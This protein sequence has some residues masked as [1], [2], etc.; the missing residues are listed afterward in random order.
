MSTAE[1]KAVIRR[2]LEECNKGKESA[3]AAMDELCAPD[4]VYHG[5]GVFPDM[6]LAAGKQMT[7][8][9]YTA[10]PDTHWAA[11]DLIAEGDKVVVRA[12]L[13][14]THRGEFMGIPPTGKAV[15]FTAIYVS[16]I[17]GGKY[18]EDSG[19]EDQLGLMQQL[20]AIPQMAQTGA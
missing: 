19:I 14:G 3:M 12:T 11:E 7:I 4:Y 16:R 8:A 5:T 17:A 13:R 1:N 2:I 9:F 20:G 10:F 18:V 15:T 6:D